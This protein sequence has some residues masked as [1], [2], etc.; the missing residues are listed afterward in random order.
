MKSTRGPIVLMIIGIFFL[1]LGI[2]GF[3]IAFFVDIRY[4]VF[5]MLLRCSKFDLIIYSA[6]ISFPA[7]IVTIVGI[8]KYVSA[9]KYNKS[10]LLEYRNKI[11][12][13]TCFH[14][15][16]EVDGFAQDFVKHRHYPEGYM[17]CPVC[18]KPLSL[19]AF[20]IYDCEGEYVVESK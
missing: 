13:T 20:E 3:L 11:F 17:S 19:N 6:L 12:A 7:L 14:C 5:F 9:K 18:H 1:L 16:Y 8:V 2:A 15:G 10:F 4:S